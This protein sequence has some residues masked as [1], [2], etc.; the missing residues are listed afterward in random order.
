[1]GDRTLEELDGER[2]GEPTFDSYVV[3]TCHALRRKP[4]NTLT[5]EELRLAV[6]QGIG[7]EWLVPLMLQ[8]LTENPFRAGD[9]FEGDL[10]ASLARVPSSYWTEHPAEKAVLANKIMTAALS[11][12]R[13][14]DRIKE[15]QQAVAE[16]RA[17]LE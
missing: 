1:M 6:G 9:L 10:L 14:P 3:R 17:A 4:L 5:D 12:D 16:L 7:L 8:R 15:T 11:D 13:L 2:W